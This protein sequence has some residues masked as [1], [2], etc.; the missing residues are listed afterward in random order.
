MH[1]VNKTKIN[2]DVIYWLNQKTKTSNH[3]VVLVDGF[4]FMLRKLKLQGAVRL[5]PGNF[6]HQRFWKSLDRT[7]N[8]NLTGNKKRINVSLYRFYYDVSVSEGLIKLVDGRASLTNEGK[9]FL[10]ISSEEQ[11]NFL[12]SKI[13]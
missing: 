8:Y 13:W 5:V 6:F 12:L 10:T 3:S 1:N 11:L 4:C 7:L 9:L 2:T